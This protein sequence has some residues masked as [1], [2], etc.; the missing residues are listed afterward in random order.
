MA[1]EARPLKRAKGL[2]ELLSDARNQALEEA[3]QWLET[4]P[5]HLSMQEYA[6]AIRAM[7]GKATSPESGAPDA[8]QSRATR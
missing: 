5:P 2:S 3:A 6:A 7:K 4:A 8:D 1:S